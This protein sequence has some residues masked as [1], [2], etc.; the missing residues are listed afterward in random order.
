M[1]YAIKIKEHV[2]DFDEI[3]HYN[4]QDNNGNYRIYFY[5]K[6][7]SDYMYIDFKNEKER[8]LYLESLNEELIDTDLNEE[9]E[10]EIEIHTI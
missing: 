6:R 4:P 9:I 8:N 10:D 7:T 1:E 2:I 3:S 5:F